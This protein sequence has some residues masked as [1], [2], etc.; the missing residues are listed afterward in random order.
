MK[1]KFLNLETERNLAEILGI[2]FKYLVYSLYI[3]PDNKKYTI[4][5]IPK[6]MGGYREIS[7]PN[8]NLLNIQKRLYA[9][10]NEI[11]IP[12]ISAHG[13]VSEKNIVTNSLP[14]VK[15]SN[16][17]NIDLKDFFPSI[18]FGRVRGLFLNSPFHIGEKVATMLAQI[19]CFDNSL[20]QGAPTSPVISNMICG[21][22][23]SRLTKLANENKSTYTRYADDITFSNIKSEF[24]REFII[25]LRIIINNEGFN[26]NEEKYRIQSKFQKQMVTG[27]VVNEFPNVKRNYIRNVRAIL[28]CWETKGFDETNNIYSQKYDKHRLNGKPSIIFSLKGK[29]DFIGMVKGKSNQTFLNLYNR[30]KIL[31]SLY[32]KSLKN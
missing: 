23:D 21:K 1:D 25:K 27:L 19:C 20:P 18:N 9:I 3:V 14:H 2:Q 28:H 22:L 11:Y 8:K 30:F 32:I 6:K 16:V 10:L 15:K 24:S 17:L 5:R 29:I 26:I 13:F 4:F 12:K 7:S 31:E